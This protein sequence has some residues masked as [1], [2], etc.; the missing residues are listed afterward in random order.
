MFFFRSGFMTAIF[1]K[2]AAISSTL[3]RIPSASSF[4]ICEVRSFTS[5][6]AARPSSE[7]VPSMMPATAN[8]D[9]ISFIAFACMVSA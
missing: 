3:S 1:R 6:M 4:A 2:A 7:N 8:L 5:L 9:A